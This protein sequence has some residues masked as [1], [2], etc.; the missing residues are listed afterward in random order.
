[1][2]NL[3][4][5]HHFYTKVNNVQKNILKEKY[6]ELRLSP[7]LCLA[8]DNPNDTDASVAVVKVVV[9][10]D[11]NEI[12]RSEVI[13][14][15][16]EYEIVEIDNVEEVNSTIDNSIE[17]EAEISDVITTSPIRIQTEYIDQPKLRRSARR[18]AK[19][20]KNEIPNSKSVASHINCIK[21]NQ[22]DKFISKKKRKTVNTN[23]AEGESSDEFPTD[24][25]ETDDFS[26]QISND[27]PKEIIKNGT[28]MFRG[29]KLMSLINKFYSLEC[30]QC[31]K[32]TKFTELKE[33]FEHYSEKHEE[34]GFVTCCQTKLIRYPVIVMHMARHLQP[35]AFKCDECGY[36]V[37]R[38]RFLESHKQTHLPETEKPFACNECPKRFSWKGA[39]KVHLISHQPVNERPRYICHI[40]GK[41]Y[42]QIHFFKINLFVMQKKILKFQLRLSWR[43]INS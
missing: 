6:Y 36:V 14:E 9:I 7:N 25:S 32:K 41:R 3:K 17:N 33:L 15:Y 39:L 12:N 11:N 1:M 29:K 37:T 28:L 43:S 8:Q 26:K 18:Q 30:E 20:E 10:S 31:D 40:C 4:D 16:E 2:R 23:A 38:P 42:N 35:E 13:E 21:N 27:F 19:P 22:K 5:F 34:K 24:E